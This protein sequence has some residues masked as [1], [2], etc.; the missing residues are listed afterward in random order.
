VTRRGNGSALRIGLVGCG[1][2]AATYVEALED[3]PEFQLVG[4]ADVRNEEARG[5]A[6]AA[7]P[8]PTRAARICWRPGRSTR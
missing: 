4:V 1:R 6:A 5:V 7:G 3:L 2:I 8:R